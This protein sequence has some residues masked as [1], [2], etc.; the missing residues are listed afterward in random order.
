MASKLQII[1][2]IYERQLEHI[3]QSPAEWTAFLQAAARNYKLPFDEQL[4]VYTQ[5]PS[6]TAV[7]PIERWNDQFN[8]WVNRGSTGIAVF[9]RSAYKPRLKYYFDIA[10]THGGR[11]A[12][13]VPI[14]EMQPEFVPDVVERLE[15]SFDIEGGESLG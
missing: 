1:T 10:D 2:Q 7:L 12:R 3:T 15:N 6:A 13:P 11:S 9:D 4:L 8:R 5:R 14:W